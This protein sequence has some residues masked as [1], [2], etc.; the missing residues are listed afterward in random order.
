MDMKR[1]HNFFA[2][3]ATLPTEVILKA[4]EGFKDFQDLGL[5]IA[6]ISHRS[7]EF[8]QVIENAETMVREIAQISDDYAVLFL[9]GGAS[10]QFAMIP[11]NFLV[12]GKCGNYAIT[13]SWSKK[14]VK[15][16]GIYGK[17]Y[18]SASSAADS[19]KHIPSIF[20]V[21]EDAAYLH[22]TSNNTIFGT[23]Y[24]TFPDTGQVPLIADMSS[25]IFSKK[26]DYNKFAMVYA[27]AQKNLGPAGVTLVMI[28]KS[29]LQQQNSP[30]S[31]IWNYQT[32][33]DKGS[34][35]NTPPVFSI[36]VLSLVLE[37]IQENGGLAGMEKI[38]QEKADLIYGLIDANPDFFRG[39]AQKN[40]RSL[41]NITLT[42]PDAE[43]EKKFI[44]EAKEND[45]LGVK[46]H[47]EVGGLRFSVYN[48]CRL[49][50]VKVLVDFMK[51]FMQKNG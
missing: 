13:G 32:H 48:S 29:M 8:T 46:G 6:E 28:K 31:T 36:Y 17:T 2:G 23:Q 21:T 10:Q 9:Q 7:P 18:E 43:L 5:S 34:L 35:F 38:N 41:M 4:A 33:I 30:L 39:H 11:Y 47:R 27:G 25:D 51:N 44:A 42:L 15:E 37:W 3:P 22:I 40:S 12:D 14:A 26:I 24:K 16:G 45:M 20:D 1:V 50:S 49:E 19:Y